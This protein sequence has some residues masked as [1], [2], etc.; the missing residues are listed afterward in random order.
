MTTGQ[1]STGLP[2]LVDRADIR[3]ELGVSRAVADA[4]FRQLPVVKVPGV[5]RA[6][7][8]AADVARA[9]ERWTRIEPD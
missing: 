6:Y 9:V 3:A 2:R 4:I 8:R 1:A 7:V 5:R